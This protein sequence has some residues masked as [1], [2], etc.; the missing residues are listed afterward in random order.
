MAESIGLS[1]EEW[2]TNKDDLM[3]KGA[4]GIVSVMDGV[5]DSID[6]SI[7]KLGFEWVFGDTLD[8]FL[9]GM[10]FDEKT[11][12]MSWIGKLFLDKQ[13]AWEVDALSEDISSE[14]SNVSESV[15]KK[16]PIYAPYKETIAKT[17]QIF[18]YKKPT[19]PENEWVSLLAKENGNPPPLDT[20]VGDSVLLTWWKKTAIWQVFP[21]AFADAKK[22]LKD[23]YNIN[24]PWSIEE[25]SVEQQFQVA[26]GYIHKLYKE[27]NNSRKEA[28]LRY[29]IGVNGKPESD[30]Q[31]QEYAQWNPAILTAYNEN[32]TPTVTAKTITAD[33]YRE[34][35]ISYYELA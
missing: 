25:L 30:A 7:D 33:Q 32:H 27:N 34:G 17:V 1:R 23:S 4:K 19:L 6:A 31:A 13:K 22:Y 21:A 12:E 28:V 24:L 18:A 11:W 26:A 2:E 14:L 3:K 9:Y 35:V 16:F 10:L 29:H 20:P 5:A 15:Y 8:D